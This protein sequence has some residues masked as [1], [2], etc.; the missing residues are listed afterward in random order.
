[1]DKDKFKLVLLRIVE[2]GTFIGAFLVL[3]PPV[4]SVEGQIYRLTPALIVGG[5]LF[6]VSLLLSVLRRAETWYIAL[7]KLCFFC[8]YAWAIHER[9]WQF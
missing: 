9:V 5:A 2:V 1:M 8:C 7:L 4:P 3:I 6:V